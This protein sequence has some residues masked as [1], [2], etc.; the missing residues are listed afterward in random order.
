MLVVTGCMACTRGYSLS[1]RAC[2]CAGRGSGSSL[3]LPSDAGLKGLVS[4]DS[5][6]LE[7]LT[8]RHTD[9]GYTGSPLKVLRFGDIRV[10]RRGL[11]L[12]STGGDSK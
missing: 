1:P 12:R 7:S 9:L 6:L 10:A 5:C 8:H 11:Y 3:G 2:L 4:M